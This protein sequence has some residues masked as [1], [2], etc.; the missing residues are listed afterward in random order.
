[1][2]GFWFGRMG[3]LVPHHLVSLDVDQFPDAAQNRLL[4]S[5]PK[6]P[7]LATQKQTTS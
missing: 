6:R 3:D 5:I 7:L 1:M 4:K 2:S